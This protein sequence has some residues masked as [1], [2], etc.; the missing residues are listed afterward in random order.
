MHLTEGDLNQY[1]KDRSPTKFNLGLLDGMLPVTPTLRK[2]WVNNVRCYCDG[3]HEFLLFELHKP[4][5]GP[6]SLPRK[7]WLR[8]ERMPTIVRKVLWVSQ[9]SDAEDQFCMS[10]TIDT[11]LPRRRDLVAELDLVDNPTVYDL[12][13]LLDVIHHVSTTWNLFGTNCRWFCAVMLLSI[14]GEFGGNWGTNG[15]KGRLAGFRGTESIPTKR[16]EELYHPWFNYRPEYIKMET[17]ET[18][19]SGREQE[20][21]HSDGQ[22]ARRAILDRF[23]AS[24][25][26]ADLDA[27]GSRFQA[28]LSPESGYTKC[29]RLQGIERSYEA[30]PSNENVLAV[31][32]MMYVFEPPDETWDCLFNRVIFALSPFSAD[33]LNRILTVVLLWISTFRLP[34]GLLAEVQA[35]S[36]ILS[37]VQNSVVVAKLSKSILDALN[38]IQVFRPFEPPP[39]GRVHS[40]DPLYLSPELT[41]TLLMNMEAEIR[42]RYLKAEILAIYASRFQYREIAGLNS[43]L[44]PLWPM[45][46][47]W[48]KTWLVF[49]GEGEGKRVKMIQ[50]FVRV[51]KECRK[52]HNYA[53]A[54]AI[55]NALTYLDVQNLKVTRNRITR[56]TLKDLDKLEEKCRAFVND[57]EET[58]GIRPFELSTSDEVAEE[59]ERLKIETQSPL[60]L[61]DWSKLEAQLYDEELLH[62]YRMEPENVVRNSAYSMAT[63]LLLSSIEHGCQSIAQQDGRDKELKRLRV[64]ELRER[65]N[66]RGRSFY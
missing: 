19:I 38:E 50:H 9:R 47:N 60:S 54:T 6:A 1:L 39:I 49:P 15:L 31:L 12:S 11:L 5:D 62:K 8:V 3:V 35:L 61:G 29:A 42:T 27:Q 43:P 51:G 64:E 33:K 55:L 13:P 46:V 44:L 32:A 53:A 40:P 56:Q 17:N 52:Q 7:F 30:D 57:H 10:S 14:E 24:R 18:A 66:E 26:V 45:I 63:S 65:E 4:N 23:V 37:R 16:V 36:T 48:A 41:A 59:L 58:H 2:A 21:D 25:E 20:V 28:L 34:R 22:Q